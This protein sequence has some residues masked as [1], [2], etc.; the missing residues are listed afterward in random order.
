MSKDIVVPT[1]V[2]EEAIDGYLKTIFGRDV[3][4]EDHFEPRIRVE[5]F[6]HPPHDIDFDYYEV[7]DEW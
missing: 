2:I 4:W 5:E 7:D 1:E 3:V 6:T